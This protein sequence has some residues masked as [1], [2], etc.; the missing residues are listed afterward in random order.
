MSTANLSFMQRLRL[1]ENH[2]FFALTIIIGIFAGLAAV[3]FTLAI[4][5]TTHLLFGIA[6]SNLR[7]IL[8][9]TL[10]SLVTGFLLAKFFPE[11]RG[12]GVP[13]IEAAYH[14]NHGEVP[15]RV[16]FGKFLTGV[17]CIGSGHSMGREGPSVQ[18][19]AGI[20]SPI[21]RWFHLS[22]A[23]AQ[24]LVPVAAAAALSAAFNTPVAAVIFA[25]EEIIGDM[26]ATLLGSTVVASVAA[27]IVERSILGNNPI[28]HVPAY[29]LVNPAELIGYLILGIVGGIV[30]LAFCKGLLHAR[31]LFRGMPKW[32]KILQPALGG[33]I[34]GVILIFFPQVMGVG[35]QFVDQAMNGGLLLKTML[36]LCF[37]KLVATI[38][39]YSSGNAGGIFAPSLYLGAMA[40]G[41]VGVLMH[42][43]APFPTGDPG[44]YALVGMGTLFA[45][46]VRAP[47][48]SVFMIFE[49]TQDYQVLVPLMVANMISYLISK[50]YQ[51]VPLY[52]ALL[53]QDD[54]HLPEPGT[55]SVNGV[56][57]ARDVM[58]RDFT[59]VSPDSS[60]QS[61]SGIASQ[62]NAESFP[63]G[64][65][66][67]YLGLVTRGQIERALSSGGANASIG[68]IAT[69]DGARVHPDHPLELVLDRLAKNPGLLPVVSRDQTDR[70]EGMIT[71]ET[72][73]Q[74]V[75]KELDTPKN[76][77]VSP[78]L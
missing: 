4:N 10:M 70:L 47:M 77:S 33:L 74:F 63:V 11:A 8:I 20:A 22:P 72:V 14:L 48:T 52:R 65:D 51:P 75:Q 30:S 35:Y 1:R 41:A 78:K 59:L 40:G 60:V 24:S 38:V 26:N 49:L 56:W 53:E 9:P 13:Q 27:V 12:S 2:I 69:G 46:I 58:T 37:A 64:S 76:G 42:R 34:I 23:R 55:G 15:F 61:A 16:A 29:H 68:S 57:R 7:Y 67:I 31:L 5:G 3:L 66:G 44:A 54:V 21:G 43:F 32:T 36:L 73:I 71:A 17:L 28:F 39:S 45:G 19:G 25:L 50:R 6:P 62:T 18:I